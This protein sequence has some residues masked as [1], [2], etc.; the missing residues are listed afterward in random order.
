MEGEPLNYGT[1]AQQH[2]GANAFIHTLLAPSWGWFSVG[3]ASVGEI[4]KFKAF[5][6][7]PNGIFLPLSLASFLPPPPHQ[8]SACTPQ[9]FCA[10]RQL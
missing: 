8:D 6:L 7:F 1:D 5:S 3:F 9:G 10:C 2:L 4:C